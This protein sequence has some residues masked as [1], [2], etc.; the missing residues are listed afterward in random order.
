MNHTVPIAAKDHL[1]VRLGRSSAAEL[2]DAAAGAVLR[3]GL[4]AILLFFGAFKFTAAE[5]NGIQPLIA[6]SPFL[7]WLYSV[8]SVRSVSNGIGAA[9]PVFNAWTLLG[10]RRCSSSVRL[11]KRERSS[12]TSRSR[13]VTR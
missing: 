7:F 2:L 5:A 11:G 9:S 1:R 8:G 13:A 3:Y 4:V 6:N 10:T 12:S